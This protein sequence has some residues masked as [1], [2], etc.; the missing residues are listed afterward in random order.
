M[1][2]DSPVQL[3]AMED[4]LNDLAKSMGCK[5]RKI[6]IEG[7]WRK[8]APVEEKDLQ[9]FLFNAGSESSKHTDH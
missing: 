3:Q 7:D 5:Y 9:Q 1:P 2:E 6:S 8:T 4:F